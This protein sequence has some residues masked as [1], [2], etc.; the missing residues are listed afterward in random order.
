[1]T[2]QSQ[3]EGFPDLMPDSPFGACGGPRQMAYDFFPS[4]HHT[5]Y[6][7]LGILGGQNMADPSAS[8]MPGPGG[9][10]VLNEEINSWMNAQKRAEE[11]IQIFWKGY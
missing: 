5:D 2:V 4:P 7:H 10:S 8:L 1:M 3:R 11:K 9:K 6:C